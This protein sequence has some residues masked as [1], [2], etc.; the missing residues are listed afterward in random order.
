MFVGTSGEASAAYS[1]L[2]DAPWA[3]ARWQLFDGASE[4]A[5]RTVRAALRLSEAEVGPDHPSQA[6]LLAMLG[7][8]ELSRNGASDTAQSLL[9]RAVE[10]DWHVQLPPELA[11]AS[12]AL[13][14][15]RAAVPRPSPALEHVAPRIVPDGKVVVGVLINMELPASARVVLYHRALGT[16]RRFVERELGLVKGGNFAATRL[17]ALTHRNVGLEYYVLVYDDAGRPIASVGNRL[18]PKRVGTEPSVR[19][20]KL[21]RPVRGPI[22]IDPDAIASNRGPSPE[23]S[24][25]R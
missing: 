12:D 19:A 5:E 25:T 10:L 11:A 17:P 13:E 23:P 7:G 2:D 4:L 3:M 1:V 24:P 15:T 14:A 18:T 22:L 6:P 20:P 8:I 21:G 16:E 9:S